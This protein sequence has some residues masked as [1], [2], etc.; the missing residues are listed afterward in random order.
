MKHVHIYTDGACSGNPGPGG[1]AALLVHRGRRKEL[2]GAERLT[3]NNRMELAAAIEG[4][5][6]LKEPC[7]VT[8][9]TDSEYL[10]QGITSWLAGWKR[11]GW[12]TTDKKPVKNRELWEKLDALSEKHKITWEWVKG[13]AE[14]P[15]NERCDDLAVAAMKA[16]SEVARNL[17]RRCT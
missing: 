13:H 5:R 2:S 15:E 16:L 17:R 9:T 1:W 7:L 12:K 6:A 10:R 14:H 8:I 3:T 11:R 4:I